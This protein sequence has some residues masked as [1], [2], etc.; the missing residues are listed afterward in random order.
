MYKK[1]Q[2]EKQEK[3]KKY[4]FQ[5]GKKPGEMP[6]FFSPV[7]PRKNKL[8]RVKNIL[9]ASGCRYAVLLYF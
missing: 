6:V 2:Y 4:T 3:T 5:S 7:L 1:S 8:F 9:S